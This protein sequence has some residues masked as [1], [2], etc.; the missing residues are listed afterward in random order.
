MSEKVPETVLSTLTD[1]LVENFFDS[2]ASSANIILPDEKQESSE[3]TKTESKESPAQPFRHPIN[4][5]DTNELIGDLLK[6]DEEPEKEEKE[7]RGPGRPPNKEP[8]SSSLDFNTFF[9]DGVLAPFEDD[10][11]IKTVEDLK[12]L[13]KANRAAD[14]EK[15]KEDALKTYKENLPEHVT[16]ILDYVENG[17]QEF[18]NF[19]KALGQ[20]Q[21]VADLSL[22][23]PSD[24][25]EIIR[26]YYT[27]QDWAPDEIDE[28]I[29]SLID[30]G[31]EKLAQVAG[32][33]KPKLDKMQEEVVNF[34]MEKQKETKA[35]QEVAQKTYVNN[36]VTALKKGTLGDITISKE[37]QQ[38]IFKALVEE[39][40]TSVSGE[41]T[42]RLGALI[43]KIQ[44]VEPDYDLLSKVT[45][46]ISDPKK[47]E[48]KIREQIKKEVTAETVKKIKGE[49]GLNKNGNQVENPQSGSRIKRLDS[50]FKNPFL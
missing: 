49:Q 5:F 23:S 47:F 41:I 20:V 24:R 11:P 4:D 18:D 26:K 32:K 2:G 17:G 34:Q 44:F 40:Y 8:E 39:R 42:N 36:V 15:G 19:L 10:A 27:L 46:Y 43:D 28:H 35:R 22:D 45:L 3:P 30:M 21:Q 25:K 50:N 1:N 33:L 31:E 6:G 14:L 48:N 38:D 16:M 37:E 29:E 13:I 7:K 12:E 9:E